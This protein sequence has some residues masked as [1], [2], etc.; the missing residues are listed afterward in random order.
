[1]AEQFRGGRAERAERAVIR[2]CYRGLDVDA[3]R[4]AL[5]ASLRGVMPVDAAF[6]ATADPETLLFTGAYAEAPL[7]TATAAFLDNEFGARD[8]NRFASLATSGRHVAWLDDTTGLDRFASARYRDIMRPLGLGDELRA[9]LVVDRRCWGYLCL[10]RQDGRLGFTAQEAAT[11][12]R[13]GPHLAAGLRQALLLQA[14]A[15]GTPVAPGV[16]LLA[17]DLTVIAV[18]AQAEYLLSLVEHRSSRQLPLP[19][20]VYT[21]ATALAALER[22]TLNHPAQPT[23]R[24]PTAAGMWLTLHASRLD[25]NAGQGPIAVVVAPAPAQATAPILLSAHGLTAREAD[26]ARLVLR[27]LSTTAIADHLHISANTVQDHLKAVFDK[28][29]VHSRRDLVGHFL[30]TPTSAVSSDSR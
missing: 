2:A 30:A 27:G 21:V 15:T 29:G 24:I 16:V 14:P 12:A 4:S 18:T 25:A 11:I 8:V 1:V 22:G 3:L 20:A 10:H 19:V 17:D 23:T 13:L 5:L 6:V 7:D 28:T 26:V 9:A